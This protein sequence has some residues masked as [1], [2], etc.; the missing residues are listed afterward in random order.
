MSDTFTDLEE[1]QQSDGPSATLERLAT[2]LSDEQNYHRLFDVLL[3]QK[4]HELGLPLVRPTSFDDVPDDQRADFE[5]HYIASAREVGGQLL[6]DGRIGDAWVYFQTIQEPGPVREALDA[7]SPQSEDYERTEELINVALYE[8][9]HPV[10]GLELMLNSHGT[11]NTITALDQQI[12]QLPPADR[13]SAAS[14]LVDQLYGDLCHTL[15]S[16]ITGRLPMVEPSDNLRELIAG[17]RDWLFAEGN[18]HIDVSHLSSVVRFARSLEPD[19]QALP[20]ALELAE[21]GSR[22]DEQFQYPAEAPFGDFYAAHAHFFRALLDD[23]RDEAVAYFQGQLESE[24]DEEDKQMI[25]YV[26]VDLLRRIGRVDDAVELAVTHLANLD[27]STGFSFADFCQVAGRLD[28]LRDSARARGDLVTW[29]GALIGAGDSNSDGPDSDG[30][31][32][33]G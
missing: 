33:D 15:N 2:V 16:E 4:K 13:L 7:V 19:S 17:D 22:L 28:L 24:P 3:M 32:A 20:K 23:S 29:A 27:E 6:D 10:K 31:E 1:L 25:A 14:L 30:N 11:C 18:Y 9:A 5:Q 21:Y 8:G 26:I 12:M